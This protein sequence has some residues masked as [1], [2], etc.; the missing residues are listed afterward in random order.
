[1][2]VISTQLRY[3]QNGLLFR[4]WSAVE[5]PLSSNAR[6]RVITIVQSFDSLQFTVTL[7]DGIRRS[8]WVITFPI[9]AELNFIYTQGYWSERRFQ[10]CF[11][12]D[13]TL[14]W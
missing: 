12:K 4:T 8:T 11:G 9:A 13:M 10:L 14:S 3:Y 2:I 5:L 1:M 7:A 6:D